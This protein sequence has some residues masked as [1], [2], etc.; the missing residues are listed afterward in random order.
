MTTLKASELQG[1]T[2]EERFE[3]LKLCQRVGD[4]T[5]G[6]ERYLN[7]SFYH[8]D[9]W[10]RIRDQVILRDNDGDNVLD[11]G[12]PDHPI[13][14]K[15]IIHHINPISIEDIEN[16]SGALIDLENLVCV[17]HMTHEAIHYSDER[18]LPKDFIERQP[19]DTCPWKG[20]CN[21]K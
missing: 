6:V 5:F 18:L 20:T 16:C 7:Q 14:G 10:K 17:S 15:V 19:D 12:C 13:S 4:Q 9:K 3:K 8:S 1:L 21:G 11:M 2:Y